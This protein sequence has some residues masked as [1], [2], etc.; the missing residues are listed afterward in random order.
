[1]REYKL[2]KTISMQYMW[3]GFYAKVAIDNSW[4][5]THWGETISLHYNVERV[6][7]V[8]VT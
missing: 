4:K 7:L 8:E 1:M 2:G 3:Q 6:L 5:N